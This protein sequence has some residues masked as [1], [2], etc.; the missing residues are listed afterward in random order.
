LKKEACMKWLTWLGLVLLVVVVGVAALFGVAW[1]VDRRAAATQYVVNDPPLV[2]PT[3]SHALAQG[4]HLFV[5]RG[6]ADCHGEDGAGRVVFEAG[7]VIRVVAPNI[8]PA[9]LAQRG[10]DADRIAAAIRHG[11]RADGTPLLFMPA[12]DWHSLGD[13]DTAAL[14]AYLGTLPA[15]D[16]DPGR[17]ELYP[18]GKVLAMFGQFPAYPAAM[19]DHTPRPRVTP[20]AK[21]S[22]EYGRYVAESCTGCHG[23]NFAGGLVLAPDTPPTANLTPTALA[24][25]SEDDFLRAMREGKRPDGSNLHPLMPWKAYATMTEVELRSLWQFLKRLPAA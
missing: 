20:E 6:C 3:D 9:V 16:S 2:L 19:L 18:F 8:T 22:V 14:V 5:T 17:S 1:V 11:V 21:V 15:R 12:G 10:Y 7:P 13:A 25:W 23:G 24:N 4:A